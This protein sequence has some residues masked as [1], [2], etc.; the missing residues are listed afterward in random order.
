VESVERVSGR[1]LDVHWG[2][3]PYREREVMVVGNSEET[4]PGWHP[5]I[6]LERGLESVI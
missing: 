3:R 1:T 5:S 6:A 4:L 2:A